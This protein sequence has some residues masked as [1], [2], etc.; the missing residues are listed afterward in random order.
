MLRPFTTS[1]STSKKVAN[2][3]S[4][5][6]IVWS[7]P[8]ITNRNSNSVARIVVSDPSVHVAWT[9]SSPEPESQYDGRNPN[10]RHTMPDSVST[11]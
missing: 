1:P 6:G 3:R 2:M 4:N 5:A 9:A 8:V 7:V 10:P 11:A